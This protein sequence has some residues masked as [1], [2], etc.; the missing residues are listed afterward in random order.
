MVIDELPKI[1]AP[2]TRALSGIGVTRLSQLPD[3]SEAE[4][5]ALHGFGPRAL[6]ILRVALAQEGMTMRP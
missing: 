2:A 5:L 6:Q 3:H 4:L 1:G